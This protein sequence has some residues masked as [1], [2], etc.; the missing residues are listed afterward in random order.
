MPVYIGTSGYHYRH[1]LGR[2]YPRRPRPADD[3][4]FYGARFQTV[5]LNATFYRLPEADTFADWAR[6][7][8]PDFI[9]AVKASRYLTHVRRLKG[10][11]EPVERLM[12]RAA[13]LGDK[14]GPVLLLLPPEFKQDT[15]RLE[16]ALAAFPRDARVAVEF[17]NE[18]W[19][20]HETHQLL[21]RYGSALCLADRGSKL[22]TPLWRTTDWGYMRFHWG[23]A[24]PESCYEP[25]V[26]A[27]RAAQLADLWGP[28]TDMFVYF[29]NDSHGCALADAIEFATAAR[30]AGLHPTRVPKRDEI[31]VG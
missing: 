7:S 1:W 9:F 17:R 29:N 20:T 15:A 3:L 12:T 31:T 28:Q 19:F 25:A 23:T 24:S 21:T 11:V 4:A 18:S 14:L 27:A 8:P 26:L 22:V 6:R 5:E 13:R 16:A 30:R 2:F 10:P